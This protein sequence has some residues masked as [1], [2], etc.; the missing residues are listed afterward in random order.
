[1]FPEINYDKVD[2][3]WGMDI[4]V[5]TTAKTDEEARRFSRPSTPVPAVS[6]FAPRTP[7]QTRKPGEHPMAKKSSSRR[8]TGVRAMT[9]R[10]KKKRADLKA[11]V[12]N[13]SLPIEDRFAATLKL[14]EMPRNGTKIRVRNR[15]ESR[16][17]AR[18]LSQAGMS[19]VAM[20]ELGNKASSP[21]SSSRAGEGRQAMSM[22]DPLGDML[23]CPSATA[24]A[25]QVAR[26]HAGSNLRARV[27]DV[28]KSEGNIRDYMTVTHTNA[29]PSSRSS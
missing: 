21:A 28:L 27:L 20:R 29:V 16:P 14:A 24:D 22:N 19:R 26:G 2:Q 4:I 9:Q 10:D 25:P 11:I 12:M 17:S 23:T 7:S 3:I 6:G 15:C 1:M 18:G 8:T 13:Q 5:C